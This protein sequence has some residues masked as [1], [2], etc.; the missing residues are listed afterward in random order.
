M[1]KRTKKRNL[2]IALTPVNTAILF[3][4]LVYFGNIGTKVMNFLG[5]N[6]NH[7]Q[8]PFYDKFTW[9]LFSSDVLSRFGTG[10]IFLVIFGIFCLIMVGMYFGTKTFYGNYIERR[11][12]GFNMKGREIVMSISSFLIRKKIRKYVESLNIGDVLQIRE[13]RFWYCGAVDDDTVLLHRHLRDKPNTINAIVS[14]D[15]SKLCE[16]DFVCKTLNDRKFC[17]DLNVLRIEQKKREGKNVNDISDKIEA[18]LTRNQVSYELNVGHK[19]KEI[20]NQ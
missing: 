9:G 14:G 13:G 8:D 1:K 4:A 17:Y 20:D 10:I 7:I 12:T 19:W 11:F 15:R 6:S 16:D 18:V 5:W 3:Y 2:L